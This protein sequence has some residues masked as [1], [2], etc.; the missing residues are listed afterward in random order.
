MSRLCEACE[1]GNAAQIPAVCEHLGLVCL[2]VCVC[3][4]VDVCT[5]VCVGV[6][7]RDR[8]RERE[9]EGFMVCTSLSIWLRSK[10]PEFV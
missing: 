10:R 7:V 8:D 3:V 9:T 1:E 6:C 4:S 2:R 5:Y